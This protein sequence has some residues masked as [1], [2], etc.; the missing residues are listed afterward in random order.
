MSTYRIPPHRTP[1]ALILTLV[2]LAGACLWIGGT[3]GCLAGG[4]TTIER[5]FFLVTTNRVPEVA[6]ITVTEPVLTETNRILLDVDTGEL[7][8]NRVTVTNL[9][10]REVTVTNLV[11]QYD[12]TPNENSEA[13]KDAGA[14]IANLLAPGSGPLAGLILGA[15]PSLWALLRSRKNGKIAASAMQGIQVFREFLQQTDEGQAADRELTRWLQKHQVE[16]GVANEVID[17]LK[18]VVNDEDA[19]RVAEQIQSVLARG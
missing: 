4:P 8:T 5:T 9:V 1:F 16:T 11:E 19:K 3:T 14:A 17:L 10:T 6:T 13:A 7:S 15:L 2:A 12:L 18:T